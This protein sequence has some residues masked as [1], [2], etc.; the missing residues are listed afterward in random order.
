MSKGARHQEYI[1]DG[2]RRRVGGLKYGV[3]EIQSDSP[4]ESALAH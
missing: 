1:V 4:C 3:E 2:V